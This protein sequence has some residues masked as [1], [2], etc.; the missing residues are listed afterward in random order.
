M[1]R[2]PVR[3]VIDWLRWRSWRDGRV[4]ALPSGT[5]RERAARGADRR[6]FPWG[7]HADSAFSNVHGSRPG[8][9]NPSP[10]GAWPFDESPWGVRDLAGNAVDLTMES[11]A[12]FPQGRGAGWATTLAYGRASR[13]FTETSERGGIFIGFRA[14][15]PVRLPLRAGCP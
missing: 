10:V 7:D 4:Y 8:G 6:A 5:L 2:I 3:R 15:S 13:V 1:F 14:F 9:V 11:E 12:A